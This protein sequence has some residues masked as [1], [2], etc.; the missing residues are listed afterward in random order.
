MIEKM[1]KV[2]LL[3]FYKEKDNILTRL[4]DLGILH[5]ETDKTRYNEKIENLMEENAK[6]QKALKILK[7]YAAE[8]DK[9]KAALPQVHRY[10]LMWQK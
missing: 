2:S 6:Y 7:I 3:L 4:Q 8:K 9:K 10:T 1:K 5:L